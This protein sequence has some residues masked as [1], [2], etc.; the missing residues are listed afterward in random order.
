MAE[1][2]KNK[3]NIP[4][5]VSNTARVADQLIDAINYNSKVMKRQFDK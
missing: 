2:L 1:I 4:E 5:I 3:L